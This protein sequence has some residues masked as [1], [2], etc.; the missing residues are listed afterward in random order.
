M[1]LQSFCASSSEWRPTG[2]VLSKTMNE[3]HRINWPP[4]SKVIQELNDIEKGSCK[5]K[6]FSG[7]SF[8]GQKNPR[9]FPI[10]AATLDQ[11]NE[12]CESHLPL[13][14]VSDAFRKL[15]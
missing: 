8:A 5:W 11:N 14:R 13:E 1:I 12:P 7:I 15:F 4:L 3:P 6:L 9:E 2:L 10:V